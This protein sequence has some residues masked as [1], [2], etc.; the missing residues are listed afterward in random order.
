M[1]DVLPQ[2]RFFTELRES[3]DGFSVIADHFSRGMMNITPT[4]AAAAV[5]AAGSKSSP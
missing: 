4:T 3:K 5:A 2:D 1:S